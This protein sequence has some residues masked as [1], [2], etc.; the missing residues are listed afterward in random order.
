MWSSLSNN[1]AKLGWADIEP[2]FWSRN[3][4]DEHYEL[5]IFFALLTSWQWMATKAGFW[6]LIS[7]LTCVS[8]WGMRLWGS[9]KIEPTLAVTSRMGKEVPLANSDLAKSKLWGLLAEAFLLAVVAA[10]NPQPPPPSS[11]VLISGER[12]PSGF[13]VF[14][15]LAIIVLWDV[16]RQS[17][18]QIKLY[19]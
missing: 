5:Q 16:C 1:D 15:S 12:G 19:V 4:C 7:R 11:Q 9:S 10:F 2:C 14:C 6:A 3:L 13:D 18:L 8:H 17:N